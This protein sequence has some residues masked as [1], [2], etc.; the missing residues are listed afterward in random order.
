MTEITDYINNDIK[1]ITV[2]DTI[3]SVQD[4]FADLSFSHFPV[5]ENGI[6]IGSISGDDVETFDA[7]KKILD[8][9]YTL[10][11]FYARKNMIWL[12]L[13]EI[14]AR[15]HT[16]IVP[17]L[18]E[19]NNY[20]GYYDITDIIKFFH[21]TPFLK[22]MGG[23][24]IVEKNIN[25]YSMSQISQIVESNNGKLL[26]MF[27]SSAEADKIQITVKIALGSL[28][29]I[30]QTFRRYNYE[31]ISEHQEDNYLNAL[32]ERSDYLDKYLNI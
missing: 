18:D 30:I 31:I 8:Y 21:E 5:L 10:E 11:G 28:N 29:D 6:Y 1:A 17:V 7:E 23:I 3:E 22:E 2:D 12:D 14:F 16:S 26:G 9:R 13:L 15:N 19:K 4:F 32:K 27:V 24:I 25:D 20:I